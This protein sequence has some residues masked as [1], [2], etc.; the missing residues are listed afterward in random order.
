VRITKKWRR[1]REREREPQRKV[2]RVCFES[3]F[4]LGVLGALWSNSNS[5]F[6]FEVSVES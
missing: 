1:E 5:N 3:V 4:S 6:P 2:E